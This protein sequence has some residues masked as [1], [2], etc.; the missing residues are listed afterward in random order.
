MQ[1]HQYALEYG[2]R[3]VSQ[4]MGC[5][6]DRDYI[7]LPST[8]SFLP[9]SQISPLTFFFF[10][11]LGLHLGHVEVPRLGVE[12]EL[13]LLA[14]AIATRATPVTCTTAHGN[15]GFLDPLSEMGD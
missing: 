3:V 15:T 5:S 2:E 12:S 14:Y 1:P 7:C 6:V 4:R 9:T 13:Q 11:F 8:H 10:C